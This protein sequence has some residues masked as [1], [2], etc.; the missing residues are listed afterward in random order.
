MSLPLHF[1]KAISITNT[2]LPCLIRRRQ[3]QGCVKCRSHVPRQR[4][5][6]REQ[7]RWSANTQK[8]RFLH[9]V[10]LHLLIF[11][12]RLQGYLTTNLTI[13]FG[14][15]AFCIVSSFGE[16]LNNMGWGELG[17]LKFIFCVR[18]LLSHNL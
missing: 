13:F 5:Q 9:H 6:H 10:L 4:S 14:F 16:K 11:S 15:L 3:K 18:P 2:P 12:L 7:S 8:K 17:W 1:L